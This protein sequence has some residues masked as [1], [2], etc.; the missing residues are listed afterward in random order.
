MVVQGLVQA[1][2]GSD[3]GLKIG[4][5]ITIKDGSIAYAETGQPSVA[6]I[7]SEVDKSGV[8]WI[9]FNGQ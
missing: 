8:A 5:H 6:N 1:N 9:M 3:S 2:V 7:L 4:D